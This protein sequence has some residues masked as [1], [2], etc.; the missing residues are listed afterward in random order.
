MGYATGHR[1]SVSVF[2]QPEYTV[3]DGERHITVSN[4]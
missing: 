3:K 2:M 1:V 4:W